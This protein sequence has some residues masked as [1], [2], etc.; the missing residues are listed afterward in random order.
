MFRKGR[1]EPT[2]EQALAMDR[3]SFA[4]GARALSSPPRPKW[5]LYYTVCTAGPSRRLYTSS[6]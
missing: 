1:S 5:R 3:C 4:A 2:G 6:R